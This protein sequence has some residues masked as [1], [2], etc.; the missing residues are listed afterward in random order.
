MKKLK[1]LYAV[2]FAVAIIA[3]SKDDESPTFKKEEFVGTWEEDD[4]EFQGCTSI[5]R[6]SDT[7]IASGSKC[8]ADIDIDEEVTFTFDGKQTFTYESVLGE[9]KYVITSK[10]ATTFK[11]K[12]V[13]DGVDFG[14]Y[15][16][17]KI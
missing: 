13:I 16:F 3:C 10:N 14:S 17:T 8:G 11:G 9:T 4:S 7:K 6:F 2:F 1:L 15:T 5:V 12:L